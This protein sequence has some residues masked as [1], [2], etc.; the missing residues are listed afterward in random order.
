MSVAHESQPGHLEI[1]QLN[2]SEYQISWRAPIY[3]GKPHPARM[4]LPDHWQLLSEPVR[5]HLS[6]S[7]VEKQTIAIPSDRFDGSRITFPGLE[8]TI[9]DVFVQVNRLDGTTFTTIASPAR[10]W[11]I[12]KGE[13][14]WYLAASEYLVR[15]FEHILAGADH[16]LFVLGLLLIVSGRRMLVKTITAFTLAHSI[17]LGLAT[18]GQLR[19]PMAPLEATIALSIL[20]LGVEIVRSWRGQ[21]S[22]AIR[23][24]WVVAL[25]FGLLH[26]FGFA[27]GLS[28]AGLPDTEILQVLLW[29]NLGVEFGQ[30]AFVAA[31]LLGLWGIKF[32]AFN[33]PQWVRRAPGYLVGCSGAFW[34]IDRVFTM[35]VY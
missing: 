34:T 22:L 15:G 14:A 7:I 32:L 3:Y 25:L 33:P 2:K 8:K 27:S 18:L 4:Q 28:V 23:H 24:P 20:F 5:A 16:L 19:I 30:L 35:M 17:T 9:T 6:D 11:S 1:Q 10:P 12:L 21:T 29:F 26:G 13:R 31:I